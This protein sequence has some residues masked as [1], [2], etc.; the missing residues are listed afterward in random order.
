MNNYLTTETAEELNRR[1]FLQQR[2]YQLQSELQQMA[3]E[4]PNV[5][6]QRMPYELLSSLAN[7]LLDNSI[8]QIV[9][10]L[11]DLQHITE[12]SL[13]ERRQKAVGKFREMKVEQQKKHRSATVDKS[14]TTE[15]IERDERR[16]DRYIDEETNKIDMKTIN[17]LDQ[18]VSDQ[19][20]TL[21]RAGVPGF[22][23]T[24]NPTEIQLQMYILDFI[25]RLSIEPTDKY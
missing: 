4:L 16:L 18:S 2:H 3:L 21:E 20:A 13:F 25:T 24:N 5:Y 14:M 1:E 10:G 6:Q 12:R 19:Q 17:E 15:E 22:Y 11:K 23:V 9:S 8:G 7:C